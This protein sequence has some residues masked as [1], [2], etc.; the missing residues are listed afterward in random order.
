MQGAVTLSQKHLNYYFYE[1]NILMAFGLN[2][3]I[4]LQSSKQ[5][6]SINQLWQFP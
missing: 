3:V 6:N 5:N 4:A 2:Y 1:T